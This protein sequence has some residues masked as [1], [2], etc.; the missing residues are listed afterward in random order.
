MSNGSVRTTAILDERARC[1]ITLQTQIQTLQERIQNTP[2]PELRQAWAIAIIELDTALKVI[3][4]PL[5]GAK[6]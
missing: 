6:L 3:T 5:Y 4:N 1:V 2:S